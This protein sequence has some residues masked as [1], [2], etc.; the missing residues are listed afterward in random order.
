MVRKRK[1]FKK[2]KGNKDSK[3]FKQYIRVPIEIPHIMILYIFTCCIP[4]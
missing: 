2:K 1:Q 3:H 4:N